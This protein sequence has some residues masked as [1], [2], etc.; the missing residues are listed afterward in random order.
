MLKVLKFLIKSTPTIEKTR[1]FLPL[2]AGKKT[3]FEVVEEDAGT[4][5][6]R[7]LR[8]TILGNRT[9]VAKAEAISM[10]GKLFGSSK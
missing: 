9:G 4:I 6:I 10:N 7:T 1:G 3:K 5:P 8:R 2:E